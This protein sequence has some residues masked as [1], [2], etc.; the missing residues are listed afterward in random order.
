MAYRDEVVSDGPSIGPS[1]GPLVGPS[2]TPFFSNAGKF[3]FPSLHGM[4][5]IVAVRY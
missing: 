5:I 4:K 3:G 1:V 2:V